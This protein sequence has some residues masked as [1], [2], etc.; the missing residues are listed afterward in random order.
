MSDMTSDTKLED[1]ISEY[2]NDRRRLDLLSSELSG[3]II[4]IE[5]KLDFYA[6]VV[7]DMQTRITKLESF[8]S[9]AMAAVMVSPAVGGFVGLMIER[10]LF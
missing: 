4:R 2:Y 10:F 9:V 1:F 8:K 5:T 3:G 6:T 7:S